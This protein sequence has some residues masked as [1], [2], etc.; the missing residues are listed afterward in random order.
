M[1]AVRTFP[2]SGDEALCFGWI[3]GVRRSL[4]DASFASRLIF[5]RFYRGLAYTSASWAC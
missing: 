2:T 4:D 1:S 3:D 5:L